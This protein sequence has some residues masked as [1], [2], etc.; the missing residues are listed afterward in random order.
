MNK[1]SAK[2]LATQIEINNFLND[3]FI[4]KPANL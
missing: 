1:F 2:K 3:I 4:K